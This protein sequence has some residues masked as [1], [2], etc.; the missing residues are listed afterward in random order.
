M[1][2]WQNKKRKQMNLWQN[3]KRKQMKNVRTTTLGFTSGSN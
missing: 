2:L 1:N 3:K